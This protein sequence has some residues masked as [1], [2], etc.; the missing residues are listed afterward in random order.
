MLGFTMLLR[1]RIAM[2]V[3]VV[4]RRSARVILHRGRGRVLRVRRAAPPRPSSPAS[5]SVVGGAGARGVVAAASYEVR[6]FGVHSAM[7]MREALRRCPQA[8]VIAP[9]RSSAIARSRRQVL[10]GIPRVHGRWSRRSRSTRPSSTSRAASASSAAARTWRARS[11][12]ASASAPGLAR[13]GRRL[14]QQAAREARLRMQKPD[15]L[16]AD[17]PGRRAHDARPAAGRPAVRRRAEDR[18]AARGSRASSRSGSCEQRARIGAVA[19]VP[20]RD[21]ARYQ[22]APP[23]ID[24]RPVVAD[25]APEK[26]ISS[27]ETFDVDIR[28]HKE[29][30]ERL[31]TASRTRTTRGCAQRSFKAG[32]VSITVRRRDFRTYHAAA[33]FEPADAETRLIAQRRGGPARELARGAAARRRAPARRRRER[34]RAGDAARSLRD[35]GIRRRTGASTT[36]LD[37]IHGRFGDEAI[38][39]GSDAV[40]DRRELHKRTFHAFASVLRERGTVPCLRKS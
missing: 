20:A 34:P 36:P 11:R 10:R 1:A 7:P 8:V 2:L 30:Q 14:A 40:A 28:D 25:V 32:M 33:S 22:T 15:G 39:R 13:F 38:H 37:R 27:E 6:R 9:A 26:Q 4:K 24:E 18:G 12:S 29:L 16:T 23:G 3:A 19:A 21:R 31:G 5:R 35:A 17:P